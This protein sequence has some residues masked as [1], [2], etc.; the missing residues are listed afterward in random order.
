M[1]IMK[2]LIGTILVIA[3]VAGVGYATY[4][5]VQNE[6][7]NP[8]LKDSALR[9]VRGPGGD[10]YRA[11]SD[12][13]G[14]ATMENVEGVEMYAI[15]GAWIW[16]EKL[17]S[18]PVFESV[19]AVE[20]ATFPFTSAKKM[21]A[22]KKAIYYSGGEQ[23]VLYYRSE[24][25]VDVY[26]GQYGWW[27]ET[28]RF[29]DC[30]TEV[31]TVSKEFYDWFTSNAKPAEKADY[32]KLMEAY[33]AKHASCQVSGYWMWNSYIEP[34][35]YLDARNEGHQTFLKLSGTV[36]GVKTFTEW[37]KRFDGARNGILSARGGDGGDVRWMEAEGGWQ[38]YSHRFFYL[39]EDP[40]T[41]PNAEYAYFIQNARPCS[42]E[43]YEE[44]AR[45]VEQ[46][47]G[48]TTIIASGVG[49]WGTEFKHELGSGDRAWKVYA[50][51]FSNG[52][53]IPVM[54]GSWDEET[55][56]YIVQYGTKYSMTTVYTTQDGW[57]DEAFKSFEISGEGFRLPVWA[58]V[59][60]SN[61]H[62]EPHE[63][64]AQ[65]SNP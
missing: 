59:F 26:D 61:C 50:D 14:S 16:N 51:F 46:N 33:V 13:I 18:A 47:W 30:G 4:R 58:G 25:M 10:T 54:A 21:D 17:T 23:I 2:K 1:K 28:M 8:V 37:F 34:C 49:Q 42:K 52:E 65:N 43:E 19:G 9:P 32:L 40:Q 24:R 45:N 64:S 44:A 7:A 6:K 5:S 11:H 48:S 3:I 38:N 22:Q 57:Q 12:V 60:I 39:G 55:Q 56:T 27:D 29:L 36:A 41:L 20:I 53:Y 35:E 31:H 62:F 15:S 63:T